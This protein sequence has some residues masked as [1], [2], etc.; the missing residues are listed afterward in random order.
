MRSQSATKYSVPPI[1]YLN[2]KTLRWKWYVLN[3][4]L[5]WQPHFSWVFSQVTRS[6]PTGFCYY[7]YHS[8]AKKYP[9]MKS[10][11]L[12]GHCAKAQSEAGLVRTAC[13]WINNLTDWSS[14]FLTVTL[15]GWKESQPQDFPSLKL[16]ATNSKTPWWIFFFFLLVLTDAALSKT[17]KC[18]ALSLTATAGL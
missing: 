9:Q 12:Y 2:W 15:R 1:I 11:P 14:I 3:Q 6:L 16:Q 17:N 5:L 13:A 10:Q 18:L 4:S 8:K 7:P